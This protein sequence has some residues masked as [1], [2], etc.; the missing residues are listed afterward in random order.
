MTT[1]DAVLHPP[2]VIEELKKNNITHVVWLPDSDKATWD[3]PRCTSFAA[4]SF[5]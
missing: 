3:W 5:T 2:A 4:P 1:H